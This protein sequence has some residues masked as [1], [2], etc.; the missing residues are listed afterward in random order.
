M[1]RIFRLVLAAIAGLVLGSVVNMA[2]VMV[3]GVVLPPPSMGAVAGMEGLKAALPLYEPRHFIFPFLAHAAGTL[4]GAAAAC[5]LSP[6]GHRGPAWAVGA[7]FLVGGA[8]NV[9]MLPSP[10]WFAVL[11]LVVAYLPMSWLAIRW[12]ERRP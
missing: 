4:V 10:M 9:T 5:W 12:M 7:I 1:A 2:L 3:G 11:D 6:D 8:V